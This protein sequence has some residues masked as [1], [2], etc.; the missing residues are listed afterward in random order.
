M[1]ALFRHRTMFLGRV[2]SM[3]I[4]LLILFLWASSKPHTPLEYMVAGTLAISIVL[5]AAFVQILRRGYL[6]QVRRLD[7]DS[8]KVSVTSLPGSEN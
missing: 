7:A 5:T 3:A 4:I 6:S 2:A 8:P 1:I